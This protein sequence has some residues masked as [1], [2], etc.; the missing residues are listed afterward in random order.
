MTLEEENKKLKKKIEMLEE[1]NKRLNK[2][3]KKI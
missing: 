2:I 3:K 1:E